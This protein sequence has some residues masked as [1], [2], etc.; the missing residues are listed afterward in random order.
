M[1][2]FITSNKNKWEEVCRILSFKIPYKKMDLLEI[3]ELDLKKILKE[4]AKI[5][6][7]NLKKPVVVEDVSLI[8]KGFNGFPGPL[9]KWVI[10]AV[11]PEGIINLCKGSKNFNAEAICGI[12]TYDGK[13][14]KYFEGK[15]KGKISKNV[16]GKNGF[17]WDPVF[18]PDGYNKTFA[19]MDI[20][21]KNK[22]S[23]RY[24]AW[25]KASNIL[26]KF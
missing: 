24:L 22:I 14:F 16:R 6:Y 7:Q 2:T 15:V 3:Q 11:G 8:L 10:K 25:K 19:E 18:I 9:I 23:H 20:E 12:C 4:K 13:K 17:G 26:K 21:E 5:A 1:F